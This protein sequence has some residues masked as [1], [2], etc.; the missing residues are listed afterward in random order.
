M[1]VVLAVCGTERYGGL[2]KY[3]YLL[4]K[5]LLKA[6]IDV[7]LLVDSPS[8]IDKAH[9]IC[10][11]KTEVVGS[12]VHNAVSTIQFCKSLNDYLPKLDFDILHTCHINP[13]FYLMRRKRKP[14]V[15]QP[16]GNELFTLAGKGL[17]SAYCKMAQP[18]LA[19][20]GHNA[21][22]LLAEGQ[23]QW[24]EMVGYYNN[25]ARMRILPVGVET[26]CLVKKSYAIEPYEMLAVNSLLP[27]EGMDILIKAFGLADIPN[28]RLTIIGTGSL[29]HE[30]M[31]LA[32]VLNVLFLK[33]VPE[34]GL[35]VVYAN[36]DLF[37]STSGETDTQMGILEAEAAG[38]PIVTTGQGWLMNNNGLL[39]DRTVE[40]LA[41][42]M[43]KVYKGNQEKMGRASRR[44]AKEY[45]F[46][47]IADGAI[48]IYER[49]MCKV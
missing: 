27:Y 15:F 20:C 28:S 36:S 42:A 5:Y 22:A 9:E 3:N 31:E 47:K 13:Y 32:K 30:L 1:R 2:T 7:T 41:G 25:E 48:K 44:I 17:N 24:D 18:L 29:E 12:P 45:S 49:L 8:G 33:N 38:V 23:F 34:N 14:V 26:N 6:G 16:F 39:C 21:D 4:A 10:D 46:E 35:R 40:A 37:V 43:N 11:V 19:Y